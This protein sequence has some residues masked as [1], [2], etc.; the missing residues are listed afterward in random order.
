MLPGS[1]SVF[2]RVTP[3][4]M[5]V[6]PNSPIPRAQV[7][8]KVLMSELRHSGKMTVRKTSHLLAPSVRATNSIRGFTSSSAVRAMRMANG[9]FTRSCANTI[10]VGWKTTAKPA[11]LS[12]LPIGEEKM[13]SSAKPSRIYGKDSVSSIRISAARLPGKFVCESV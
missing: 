4:S 12:A 1:V 2:M 8:T 6:A 11:A 3:T 5:S 13:S 10:P 7:S 9:R